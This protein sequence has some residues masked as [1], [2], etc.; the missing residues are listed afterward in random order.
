[1]ADIFDKFNSAIDV[2]GLGKDVEDAANGNGGN[3]TYEEV[4][5]GT[6]EVKPDKAG[7]VGPMEVKASKKGD[8]MVC[9]PFRIVSGEHKGSIVFMN[10]VITRGFQIHN[11][12]ELLRS[13]D[14]NTVNNY[15]AKHGKLWCNDFR[16]YNQLL[17]DC[18][19][20]IDS[21]K[22]TFQLEYGE[23]NSGFKT[24]EITDVFEPE[25]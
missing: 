1:M 5:V 19:E 3:R 21:S 20:E 12:D 8:P 4:P 22:L 14:L 16:A 24:F 10:Q 11:V 9:I 6:Y 15:E 23:N 17:M 2:E 25:A 18:A 13:M 7:Q